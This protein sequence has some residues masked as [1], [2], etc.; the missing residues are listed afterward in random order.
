M[1]IRARRGIAGAALAVLV[2]VAAHTLAV[3]GRGQPADAAAIVKNYRPVSFDRLRKPEDGDWLMI[4]RTYDGW[5]FSPLSQITAANVSRL[6][7]VWMLET[8]AT[9]GHEA[10]PLVNN[11][12]MFVATPG[13]Q[14]IALEAATGKVV[15]RYQRPLPEGVVLLHPRAAVSRC[16]KT[17][18]SSRPAKRCSSRSMREPGVKSGPRP[19]RTTRRATTSPWHRSSR[20]AG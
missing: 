18:C 2:M 8:G 11:G 16:M 1:A 7:R 5:G 9:N 15:W 17:R 14:V 12:V 10:P 6:E 13:K 20:M 19:W 4:R 3:A